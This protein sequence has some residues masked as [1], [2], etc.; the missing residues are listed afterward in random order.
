MSVCGFHL[1]SGDGAAQVPEVL[2][3]TPHHMGNGPGGGASGSG[4]HRGSCTTPGSTICSSPNSP[5]TSSRV[6]S[7]T[8][9]AIW[10]VKPAERLGHLVTGDISG[11]VGQCQTAARRERGQRLAYDGGLVDGGGD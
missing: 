1:G 10:A 9:S 11:Q 4:R 7:T 3:P 8:D 6:H 2:R 5:A